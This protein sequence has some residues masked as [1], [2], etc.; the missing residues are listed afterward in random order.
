VTDEEERA[1]ALADKL[2]D[3]ALQAANDAG[4]D[5]GEVAYDMWI[6]LTRT[7]TVIGWTPEEL[8]RDAGWHSSHQG[9]DG[10]A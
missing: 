2:I 7:L 1:F 10:T 3:D 8:M 4:L 5:P 6:N 9:S